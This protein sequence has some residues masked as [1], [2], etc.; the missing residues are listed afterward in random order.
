MGSARSSIE[1]PVE[2]LDL[3]PHQVGAL[4]RI[5]EFVEERGGEAGP[6]ALV[7]MPTGTGKSGVIAVTGQRLV[8][9]GDVLLLTPW[10]ALVDQLTRDVRERF[11]RRVNAE[12]PDDKSVLRIFPSTAAG[13][14]NDGEDQQIYTATIATLQQ[15]H[16]NDLS[17]YRRLAER[18]SLVIVDEGHYE[19][20]P[21]WAKSVRELGRPTILFTAT[22]YRNDFK[23]FEVDPGFCFLY[24]HAQAEEERFLRGVKFGS[25]AFA[26]VPQFCDELL[27]LYQ[28]ELSEG[29]RVIVRC[30]TK[31]SVQSVTAELR[32]RNVS[33]IGIHERFEAGAD[34]GFRRRVPNPEQDDATFWVHQ[35][36]LIEGIDDPSFQLVAF[37]EPF[38]N[39]RAFVQQVGRVLRNPGR[40][41][42]QYAWVFS[43]PRRRLEES[44]SAYRTYDER[45]TPE[46][47]LTGPGEFAR[48]QPPIQY[49]SGLFREPLD[50]ASPTAFEDFNYPRSTRAFVVPD[51]FSLDAL[52]EA[53][54]KE[55]NEFDFDLQP[56]LA[57]D[58]STRVHPYIAIG[59]SPLA[60]RKAFTEYELGVTVY[61]RVGKYLFFFDSQGIT[62]E[63]LSSFQQI[64]T[65]SLQRL[66]AGV[67]ARITAVSLRNTSLGRQS[68]RRRLLQAYAVDELAPDLS[69]HGHFASTATGVT[70]APPW[71]AN[72]T[73]TR[74][75]GFTKARI[76]DRAGGRTPFGEY[77]QWLDYIATAL[78]DTSAEP[79]TVFDRYAE[80]LETPS[81]TTPTSILLD[82]NPEDFEERV[83]G[84]HA[85]LMIDDLCLP[86][87]NGRFQCTANARTYDVSIA[88]DSERLAYRLT[89]PDMDHAFVMRQT[90]GNRAAESVVGYL[91]REQAFRVIPAS[92]SGDYSIYSGGR[93][94]RP[95]LAL[96]GRVPS[97]RFDL[98]QILE[99][100]PRLSQIA[101]EKGA[102]SSA[103][104]AGWADDSLFGL[105]DRQGAETAMASHF[106]GVSL[107][108]CD[109]M[110][111]EIA[112]FVAVD[113][114]GRRVVAI[115]AKAFPQAKPLSAGALHEISSQALKNLGYLQP[116]FVGEPKNLN[117]WANQWR[118]SQGRVSTRIRHGGPATPRAAWDRIRDVLLDPQST[119][120][121]W[122]VLGQGLSKG[123]LDAERQKKRPKAEVV[124]LLYSLQ[125][126]WSSVSSLG[127]RFR[128]F[129]SP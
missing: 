117:R 113:E 96:W 126:T 79:L 13:A 107:M 38:S 80:V 66:Y 30:A 39:E 55:W 108:V 122:L 4:A 65:A 49:V 15:L 89:C 74:Y 11:W 128:V 7:R 41:A 69:D 105:I 5:S 34:Q 25:A 118:G 45:A 47:L 59:N 8:P 83:G 91:N 61:R 100:V 16:S 95:R 20:A 23:F 121:V 62:P 64:S 26:S 33:A 112:D 40:N 58:E 115:H 85:A 129:C 46:L 92:A 36:K 37:F 14:L 106:Q 6:S 124:Q 28:A 119:R 50:I 56:A 60:L 123:D 109:D 103:T 29:A 94:Y 44:W 24:S 93:F 1:L 78:D 31:N 43:D 52:A 99:A 81:D 48:L 76:S 101:S 12:P 21:A 82:F 32:A 71:S 27:A 98:L 88:W 10:D 2:D 102:A 104:A 127:A 86:V 120:E 77:V 35:N 19:P 111:T 87:S 18:A 125:S 97:R 3:W 116:Y 84:E 42:D 110:G 51:D 53:V 67:E 73:L 70:N 75:V 9:S 68:A 72:P 114:A 63:E 57:P 22:P 17:T 90:L 54:E